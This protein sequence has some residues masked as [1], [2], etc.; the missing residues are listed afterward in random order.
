MGKRGSEI[1]GDLSRRSFLGQ[2]ALAA[3]A[4][5]LAAGA[6]SAPPNRAATP[7][8]MRPRYMPE[9]GRG[10]IKVLFLSGYHPYDRENLYATFDSLGEDITWVNCKHPAAEAFYDPKV[11]A[12]FDVFLFYDAFMGAPPGSMSTPHWEP[13]TPEM[14][15]GLKRMTQSGEKGFVFMHHALA[16]WTH[17]WPA[18]V[19][20]N[21]A[22]LEMMG[23]AADWGTPLANIRGKDYPVSG[24]RQQTEQHI[25][26]VDKQHPVTAG[27]DDGSG[28]FDIVDETYLCPMF[29]DSV[30][31]LLRSSFMPTADKFLHGPSGHHCGA[32]HPPGSNMTAW[33]K[34]AERSPVVYFQHGHD[35]IAWANRYFRTLLLNSIKWAASPEA[36]SWAQANPTRIFV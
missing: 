11:A 13:P 33:V 21:N 2:A 26:I 6:Q 1:T 14:Q 29:E 17:S 7:A 32:G 35:N 34:T 15:E 4:A 31:C 8:A 25:T 16:A 23:G 24:Y 20:G 3:A 18:G 27:L 22:Y 36:K 10:P 12:F 28:G 9:G 5:P 19:N 30:H